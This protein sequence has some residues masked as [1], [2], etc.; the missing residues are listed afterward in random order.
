MYEFQFD[1]DD[2][3]MYEIIYAENPMAMLAVDKFGRE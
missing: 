2:Y 3:D 1:D